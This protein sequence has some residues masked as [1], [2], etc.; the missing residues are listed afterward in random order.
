[1]SRSRN[2]RKGSRNSNT[3]H[4]DL[5]GAFGHKG[6]EMDWQG[7]TAEN[8]RFDRRIDRHRQKREDQRRSEEDE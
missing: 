2:S 6:S 4:K 5:S 1:M 3:R 7:H 8:K